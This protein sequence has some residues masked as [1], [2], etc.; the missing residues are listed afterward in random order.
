[1]ANLMLLK[2]YWLDTPAEWIL[3]VFDILFVIFVVMNI[4]DINR[5]EVRKV[6]LTTDK[7]KKDEKVRFV[8]LAD[9]HSHKFSGDNEGLLKSIEKQNP[10]FIVIGGDMM[11]ARPGKNNRVAISFLRRLLEKNVVYYG[12]GNHEHRSRLYPETYGKMYEEYFNA[13]ASDNLKVLDNTTMVEPKSGIE[14]AGLTIDRSYYKRF[15]RIKMDPAYVGETVAPAENSSGNPY[16]IL[17]AHN[18]EYGD[19]YFETDYDLFLSGHLH[20]GII[21]LPGIGGVAAPSFHLFPK[22]NGGLYKNKAGNKAGYVSC[23]LGTHTVPMR[24]LNPGE[25]TVIEISGK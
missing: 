14:I 7:L 23:G 18:P 13:I 20:G 17:I 22:Y 2:F 15:K 5:F 8:F 24:F 6:K 1:M 19:A 3:L 12:L 9:L 11:T 25:V 4:V 21:R 10:D 16:K